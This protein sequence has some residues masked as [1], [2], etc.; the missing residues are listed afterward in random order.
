M[1]V[2]FG[3][4]LLFNRKKTEE[5]QD[6][7]T[8]R[9]SFGWPLHFHL[10]FILLIFTRQLIL[11]YVILKSQGFDSVDFFHMPFRKNKLLS[12]VLQSIFNLIK[13]YEF[14]CRSRNS[15]AI[16]YSK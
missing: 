14:I 9:F 11:P 6:S 15:E 16:K 2:S 5:L 8:S 7:L 1:I 12:P 13:L 10:L 3:L 4:A